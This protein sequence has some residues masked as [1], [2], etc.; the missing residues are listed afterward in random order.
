MGGAL[1][2][3]FVF[4]HCTKEQLVL[5]KFGLRIAVKYMLHKFLDES[6]E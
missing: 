4:M 6:E 3:T 5:G 2:L 1:S